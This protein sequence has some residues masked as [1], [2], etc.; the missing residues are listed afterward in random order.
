MIIFD[1]KNSVDKLLFMKTIGQ[2]SAPG[3][4]DQFIGGRG[5]SEQHLILSA[6]EE[7]ERQNEKNAIGLVNALFLAS[8]SQ[9][10][11]KV[12]LN[13]FARLGDQQSLALLYKK[14]PSPES[15]SISLLPHFIRALGAIGKEPEIELIAKVSN[16]FWG[17]YR[18]EVILSFEQIR[19]RTGA[20]EVSAN[21]VT[22]LQN[23]YDSGTEGEKIRVLGLCEAF[24][25]Q[26]LLGIMSCGL[27]SE[28]QQI[29][30]AAIRALGLS[31][32]V[33]AERM[34]VKA[35]RNEMIE[36]MLVS[37]EPWL[38]ASQA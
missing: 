30:K 13:I 19:E 16:T 11:D 24:H 26:L 35:M 6:L 1:T 37:Y 4:Y 25:H 34:L 8:T 27:D 38:F 5:E 28:R 20:T 9:S 33:A 22:A 21:V 15:V 23:L 32:S 31:K 17:L 12:C 36:D 14:Y 10:L 7:I 2:S 3:Q 29:R 18:H